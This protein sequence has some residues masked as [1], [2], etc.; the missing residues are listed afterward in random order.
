MN[1]NK[2]ITQLGNIKNVNLHGHG[3]NENSDA[4]Q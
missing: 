1:E 4:K 3:L 2:Q